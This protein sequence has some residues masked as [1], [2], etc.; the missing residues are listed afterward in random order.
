MLQCPGRLA[1][2]AEQLGFQDQYA[3]SHFF[4]KA[5]GLSPKTF[6]Q[7]RMVDSAIAKV[8]HLPPDTVGSTGG[9]HERD[10][11]ASRPRKEVLAAVTILGQ[12][13]KNLL[14]IRLRLYY[15]R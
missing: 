3:F 15:E 5:M 6:R 13:A 14:P 12:C 2:I 9:A 11:S 8:S 4:K 7:Q 10:A 1:D